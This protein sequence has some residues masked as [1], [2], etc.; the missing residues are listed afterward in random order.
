MCLA[1]S[2]RKTLTEHS[3]HAGSRRQ[4]PLRDPGLQETVSTNPSHAS[5]MPHLAPD[6]KKDDLQ[7][8]ISLF[9][10]FHWEN[11]TKEQR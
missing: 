4:K 1:A 3:V 2:A 7:A 5:R 10:F 8:D 6:P 11:R 9:L